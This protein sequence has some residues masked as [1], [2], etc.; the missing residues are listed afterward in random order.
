MNARLPS[1]AAAIPPA[2]RRHNALWRL[3]HTT[4]RLDRRPA[5]AP[6]RLRCALRRLSASLPHHC[7][8]LGGLHYP[9][10]SLYI[11]LYYCMLIN[12]V[13]AQKCDAAR[14]RREH[15]GPG[16]FGLRSSFITL[17]ARRSAYV[18]FSSLT[19]FR[20]YFERHTPVTQT[21]T[22]SDVSPLT[23]P[24]ACR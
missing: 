12:N 23:A 11:R 4:A 21:Q 1:A 10:L 5:P 3:A 22:H 17:L 14:L 6:A 9:I 8:S 24:A 7:C 16:V 19:Q 2:A 18:F 20:Y 15:P 13:G